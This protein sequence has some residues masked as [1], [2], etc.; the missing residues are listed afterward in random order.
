MAKK[1]RNKQRTT[2]SKRNFI[3]KTNFFL[4]IG[5][6]SFTI[7]SYGLLKNCKYMFTKMEWSKGKKYL[8]G[9]LEMKGEKLKKQPQHNAN[10]VLDGREVKGI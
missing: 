1:K 10:S 6:K 7:L 4:A 5:R 2:E 8:I 3:K 9:K